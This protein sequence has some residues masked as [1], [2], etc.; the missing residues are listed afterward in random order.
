[1]ALSVVDLYSKEYIDKMGSEYIC[2][3]FMFDVK[4]TKK[5]LP[6]QLASCV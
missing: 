1:M 5:D 4:E 2:T 3:G 6:E